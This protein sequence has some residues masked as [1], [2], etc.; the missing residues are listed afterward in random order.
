MIAPPPPVISPVHSF[1]LLHFH[2]PRPIP[3]GLPLSHF[4]M[5]SACCFSISARALASSLRRFS[6]AHILRLTRS[7]SEIS[8]IL[9][10]MC[11]NE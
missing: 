7:S 2:T 8:L 9:I 5:S 3:M 10:C 4:R 6:C 11:D 1:P